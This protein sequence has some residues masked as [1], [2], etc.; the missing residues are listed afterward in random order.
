[1]GI[2]TVAVYSEADRA[3]PHARRADLSVCIG[4]AAASQSYLNV[5][6]II[7][8]AQTTN[9]DAIHPGYGFLSEN[10][11]LAEACVKNGIVF[12][13]PS[14]DAIQSMG[15]KSLAKHIMQNANLPLLPGYHGQ[16]QTLDTLLREARQ[17]GFP[18]LIKAS[19]GGGGK[20]LRIVESES[21]FARQLAHAQREAKN[22]F[23]DDSVIIEKYLRNS[24]H[25]EVQIFADTHGNL[26]HLFDRDCSVQRRYQK[27][28]EEAPAT[29][30]SRARRENLYT[31]ALKAAR[32]IDYVGAG[33]VEFLC[34]NNA[35]DD[36]Y[37]MEMNTRLQVEHPLTEA[38]TGIDLVEWQLRVAAG[39][40]LPLTQSEISFRGHAIEARVYAEDA[41]ND[42]LPSTGVLDR[43]EF[44]REQPDTRLDTGYSTGNTVGIHYD[45]M[46]AKMI[47]HADH[48]ADAV[49]KIARA[50]NSTHIFGVTTNI[51]CL[52][53]IVNHQDFITGNYDT[54][55]IAVN[56]NS[57]SNLAASIAQEFLA[58]AA[59]YLAKGFGDGHVQ[60]NGLNPWRLHDNWRLLGGTARQ[61]YQLQ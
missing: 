12:V 18:V 13:G 5:K 21:D 34:D 53:N 48:R 25:I 19:A 47:C 27:V 52:Y 7:D 20:G 60:T 33:T 50:L 22:A 51:N 35:S 8:A 10:P 30:I 11:A 49:A 36:G 55:F 24:R 44:A 46:L 45:P 15:S 17:C 61:H 38:I 40:S 2:E 16:D 26:V 23:G 9:S 31:A 14:V 42:F 6:K 54:G 28:I 4:P 39:E 58:F 1:M 3:L 59:I 41:F 57:L 56:A 43:F 37:F 29:G 32:A